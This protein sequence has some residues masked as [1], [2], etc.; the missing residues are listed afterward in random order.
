MTRSRPA[1]RRRFPAIALGIA[2]LC[3]ASTARAAEPSLKATF[4][5]SSYAQSGSP[6]ENALI[7]TAK[8]ADGTAAADIDV[9]VTVVFG[10]GTLKAPGGEFG[11]VSTGK[12]DAAGELKLELKTPPPTDELE[13][14]A[15]VVSV[16]ATIAGTDLETAAE[17]RLVG[18]FATTFGSERVTSELFVGSTFTREYDDKR[19]SDGFNDTAGTALLRIDTQFGRDREWKLHTGVDLL[20]AAFPSRPAATDGTST[21]TQEDPPQSF[22]DFADTFTGGVYAIWEPARLSTH[23]LNG[24]A[25]GDLRRY[26]SL[27]LGLIAG[28]RVVSLEEAQKSGDNTISITRLGFRFAHFRTSAATASTMNVNDFPIRFIEVSAARFEQ[29]NGRDNDDRVI[30][31]AGMRLFSLGGGGTS[32]GVPFYAGIYAN[33]GEGADD[34]RFFAGF[35]FGLDRV[36]KIFS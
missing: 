14:E 5:L 13:Q 8:N 3:L 26:D 18:P 9:A 30:I 23:S 33:V 12:A 15:L 28:V 11:E 22:T 17:S 24:S 7:V 4:S 25:G 1:T 6:Y 31:D 36:V 19:K 32:S 16:T 29:F 27:R 35:L 10:A 34:V 2:S 20:F 21:A